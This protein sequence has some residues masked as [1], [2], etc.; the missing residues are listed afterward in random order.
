MWGSESGPVKKF[1]CRKW[2]KKI[3]RK[4]V[5]KNGPFFVSVRLNMN[6]KRDSSRQSTMQWPS[7]EINKSCLTCGAR[8][9]D[10]R[11]SFTLWSKRTKSTPIRKTSFDCY[12][13]FL[14]GH[15]TSRREPKMSYS[16]DLTCLKALVW[17]FVGS[18]PVSDWYTVS[19]T[20][21]GAIFHYIFLAIFGSFSTTIENY[22]TSLQAPHVK[23]DKSTHM[24]ALAS[25]IDSIY[26]WLILSLKILFGQIGVE[27]GQGERLVI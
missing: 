5:V 25:I 22:G 19:H 10:R 15:K 13:W 11:I 24:K 3:A 20:R 27:K 23:H 2:A 18:N 12:F 17:F 6:P 8:S 26:V 14:F 4:N 9:L 7:N 1:Y 21:K 16:M